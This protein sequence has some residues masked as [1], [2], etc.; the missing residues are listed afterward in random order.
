MTRIAG[1]ASPVGQHGKA[2]RIFR[3][4]LRPVNWAPTLTQPPYPAGGTRLWRP[5]ACGGRLRSARFASGSTRW[6]GTSSG[7]ATRGLAN[8]NPSS[9][10]FTAT[11]RGGSPM[12]T[13][14]STSTARTRY[15]LP[16]AATKVET[17]RSHGFALVARPKRSDARI[18]EGQR[19]E[20]VPEGGL[21]HLGHTPST[22]GCHLAD[23]AGVL[24]LTSAKVSGL[25]GVF[26]HLR[27]H[28]CWPRQL[29]WGTP[30]HPL[31]RPSGAG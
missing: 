6:S 1:F 14:S 7:T 2:T 21:A 23:A 16:R 10:G 25:S 17:A 12:S 15:E 28:R 30:P 11:G 8:P 26:I 13:G 9:T 18:P 31:A 19:L 4:T 3:S 5:P 24:S 20:Q 22:S 29:A 27:D